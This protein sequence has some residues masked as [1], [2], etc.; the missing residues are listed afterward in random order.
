MSSASAHASDLPVLWKVDPIVPPIARQLSVEGT[1]R[2]RL[3][4]SPDGHVSRVAV[5]GGNPILLEAAKAAVKQWVYAPTGRHAEVE[6]ALVF[7]L[8]PPAVSEGA[9]AMRPTTK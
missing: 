7:R 4:V 5:L 8:P 9:S 2:L 1:V 3:T 6:V